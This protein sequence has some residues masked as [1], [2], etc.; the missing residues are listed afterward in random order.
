MCVHSVNYMLATEEMS[1]MYESA[2]DAITFQLL[3]MSSITTLNQK[4]FRIFAQGTFFK[5]VFRENIDDFREPHNEKKSN[6]KLLVN[7]IVS[8][9]G[10]HCECL[11]NFVNVAA[12]LLS[13]VLNQNQG[14]H[15][16]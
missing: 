1:V 13:Q 11:P 5:G 16:N 3:E 9:T 10:T 4:Q 6:W 14:S 12:L 2:H 7:R 15:R 8:V